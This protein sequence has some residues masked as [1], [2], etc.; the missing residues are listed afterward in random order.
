MAQPDGTGAGATSADPN[1][2]QGA[3]TPEQLASLKTDILNSVNAALTSRFQR[4]GVSGLTEKLA[5]L[6]GKLDAIATSG[7]GSPEPA[8]AADGSG[9]LSDRIAATEA[10]NASLRKELGESRTATLKEQKSAVLRTHLAELGVRPG[11]AL[12]EAVGNLVLREDITRVTDS[13][14]AV[15]W[16]GK[17]KGEIGDLIDA[18]LVDVAKA[19]VAERQYLLPPTG[20]GGTEAGGGRP[21]APSVGGKPI[22]QMTAEEAEALPKEE[23]A[24]I[25][26]ELAGGQQRGFFSSS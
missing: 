20:G 5:E 13:T 19:F 14:G 21:A 18:P 3:V 25:F 8:K 17:V 11:I 23:K 16:K 7:K 1:G 4:E 22:D 2:Q 12:E 6:T 9:K 15:S 10:E 24:K 26:G